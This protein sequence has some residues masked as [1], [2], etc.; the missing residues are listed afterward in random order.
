MTDYSGLIYHRCYTYL[1]NKLRIVARAK[2]KNALYYNSTLDKLKN[3][4]TFFCHRL[5]KQQKFNCI[6]C[7][8]YPI[9]IYTF[10]QRLENMTVYKVYK[11]SVKLSRK[12]N[13][14]TIG[15]RV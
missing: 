5:N 11:S 14:T 2:K 4:I 9:Y 12:Y 10:M 1:E 13:H 7:K 3:I 6:Y 15:I 8:D